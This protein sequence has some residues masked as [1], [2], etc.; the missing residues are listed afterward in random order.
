MGS[1]KN[2]QYGSEE[3][4][5]IKKDENIKNLGVFFS[6]KAEASNI[7]ENWSAK[8]EDIQLTVQR[9]PKRNLSLAG[10]V[11]IANTL[12][13]SKLYYIIQA[14]SRPKAITAQIDSIMFKFLWQKKTTQTKSLLKRLKE[15]IYARK[16]LTEG[17]V[18][19][20]Y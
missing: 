15:T 9:W 6:T 13:L 19:S 16:F 11:L 12:L 1:H 5:W 14:L 10:K 4:S 8:I 18:P 7:P 20:A 2:K 3:I 17:L